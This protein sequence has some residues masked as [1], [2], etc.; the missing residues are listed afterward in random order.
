MK[1]LVIQ[2]A[3]D[4]ARS[5]AFYQLLGFSPRPDRS[6]DRWIEHDGV[7]LAWAVHK[8]EGDDAPG[9]HDLS[10]STDEPLSDIAARLEAG[11]YESVIKDEPWGPA[12]HTTDPDGTAVMVCSAAG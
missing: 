5:S 12:L 8:A 4:T 10:F 1:L 7:E 3:T 9:R 11:G 6:A 2:Y